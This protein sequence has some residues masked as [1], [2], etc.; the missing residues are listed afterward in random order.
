MLLAW[1]KEIPFAPLPEG[2]HHGKQIA[3]LGRKMVF[4]VYASI[5][6]WD[7]L[8]DAAFAERAQ[9]IGQDV[10][11]NP[12]A[13]LELAKTGQP[14]ECIANNQERPPISNHIK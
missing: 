5:R 6:G 3:T 11:R 13:L 10:L 12:K 2:D 9:A 8:E 14:I 1:F 7:K 4:L